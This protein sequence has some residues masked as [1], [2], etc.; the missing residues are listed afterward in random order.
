MSSSAR[1]LLTVALICAA[2]VAGAPAVST[3]SVTGAAGASEALVDPAAD[4]A[5]DPAC[6]P[7]RRAVVHLPDGE[8]ARGAARGSEPRPYPCVADTGAPALEPTFGVTEEG[9]VLY[10]AAG[11]SPVPF[12]SAPRVL[13]SDD[14]GRSWVDV[15]PRL[16]GER[17]HR[18]SFD[19]YMYVDPR[20]SRAFTVDALVGCALVSS[21]DD[22]GES[23][24]STATLC[25]QGLDHQSVFAGPPVTSATVGY[26][27][28]VYWCAVHGGG[29]QFSTATSCSKS[30]DGGH[31]FVPTGTPAYTADPR[32]ADGNF[33]VSGWCDGLAGRGVVGPSGT[34][35]VPKGWC[36]EPTLAISDDEGATWRHVEV[37][38][39]IGM[40]RTRDDRPEHEAGVAVDAAG[41]LYFVWSGR[42]RLPYLAVSRDGGS[43]WSSPMMVGPPDLV[44]ADRPQVAVGDP[45]RIVIG[46]MGS[47]DSPGPPFP[48]EGSC[49]PS[50]GAT[51]F[52]LDCPE[53]E[54]YE[55]VTWNGYLTV[56]T[57]ALDDRP[58][59][60][61]ATVNDPAEP[62]HR[63]ACGPGGC[64][65]LGDGIATVGTGFG[66]TPL[67][68]FVDLCHGGCDSGEGAEPRGLFARLEGGP[69]LHG[70]ASG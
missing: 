30:L 39:G 10:Q 34:I 48:G 59:L 66:G 18:A 52:L 29:G 36:G 45:G 8:P 17:L 6:D 25:G 55:D 23:W 5:A 49:G 65:T 11:E 61:T 21:S 38:S 44:E 14:A 13:R 53:P 43:T 51:T 46:Y 54:E 56:T 40:A 67:G 22:G 62:L 9:S 37:A 27:N 33:G 4:P 69:G 16:G 50:E 19:P 26:P 12:T 60:L 35:Y 57:D 7:D 68:A 31:T 3:G 15:S 58:V 1:R 42:D 2:A 32:K 63:G 41:N 20:T 28:V 24:R 47:A 64:G 70:G